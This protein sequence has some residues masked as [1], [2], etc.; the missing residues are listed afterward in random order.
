MSIEKWACE[1][2]P[3]DLRKRAK[4]YRFAAALAEAP[5]EMAMFQD[6]AISFEQ[7]A[8]QIDRATPRPQMALSRSIGVARDQLNGCL[9]FIL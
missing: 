7:L 3:F 2:S 4:L 6:L 8:R 9:S 5:G 1:V